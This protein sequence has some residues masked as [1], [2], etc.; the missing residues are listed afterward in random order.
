MAMELGPGIPRRCNCGALTIV[1]TSKT[2]ENPGRK[3]YRCCA[4]FSGNHVFKWADEAIAE[5]IE[6]IAGKQ[7]SMEEVLVGIREEI[8]EFKKD[9][10]EIVGLL[11]KLSSK[12]QM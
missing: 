4:V 5:E 6:V 9:I 7:A 12:I 3:F 10:S 2:R 1:V 8:S 11:D